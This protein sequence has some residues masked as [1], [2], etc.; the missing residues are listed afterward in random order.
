MAY[1][2]GAVMFMAGGWLLWSALARRARARAA[3][4]RGE[5]PP[6]LNRS[7]AMMGDI[8]PPLISFGLLIA[9]VQVILAYAV[10]GGMGF[11]LFD[12]V[13]FLFLLLAYDVWVRMKTRYRLSGG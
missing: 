6:P 2:T 8:V 4:E 9:A 5:S 13:G 10:T 12:L 3:L 1:W 7:L 11:T